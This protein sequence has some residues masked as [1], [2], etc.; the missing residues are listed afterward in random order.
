MIISSQ[1]AF[2]SLNTNETERAR[3][4]FVQPAEEVAEII[5]VAPGF[6][7]KIECQAA[8]LYV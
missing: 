2:Q 5:L 4:G 7:M 1:Q 3:A 6:P 8:I